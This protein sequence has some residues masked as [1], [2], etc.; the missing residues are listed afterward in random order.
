MRLRRF[1]GRAD[2][3]GYLKNGTLV[4]VAVAGIIAGLLL[5]QRLMH[6]AGA[7]PVDLDWGTVV[8][9]VLATGA[10]FV[11]SPVAVPRNPVGSRA[12]CIDAVRAT[13]TGIAI[14]S[15]AVALS[16]A[17]SWAGWAVFWLAASSL[18]SL[19]VIAPR[20]SYGYALRIARFARRISQ[21]LPTVR[22][23][24][25]FAGAKWRIRSGWWSVRFWLR[26][27]DALDDLAEQ[28][29][30]HPSLDPGVTSGRATAYIISLTPVTD[31]PRVLRQT[32]MLLDAGWNVVVAGFAGRSPKPTH[33]NLLCVQHGTI[34]TDDLAN[35][36]RKLFLRGSKFSAYCAERYYWLSA[37]YPH[38]F[39]SL[40]HTYD[41]HP[42]LGCNLVIAHDYYTAPIAARLAAHCGVEFAIDCH[43]YATG[44]Y[45]HDETWRLT[46][47][48]WVHAIQKRFLPRAAVVTTVCDG[49][50]SLID[51]EYKLRTPAKVVRSMP[52]FVEMPFRP[53]GEVIEVLYHGIL[54]PIRGLD[55]AM[56]SVPYWRPEFRLVIR[57]PG[58]DEYIASLRELAAACGVA[59]RVKIDPPVLFSE[60]IAAANR[61]DIGFF[62]H[63]DVSPQ[64]RFVLPNKLFEYIMAGMAICVSDLPE[65]AKVVRAHDLG[66]LVQGASPLDIARAINSFSR[67]DIDRFKANSIAAAKKLCWD[68]ES[69]AMHAAYESLLGGSLAAASG[70]MYAQQQ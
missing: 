59:D 23:D 26:L 48:P 68:S 64:K 31:E 40:V 70:P 27:L 3:I 9:S 45:M 39:K 17:S 7:G 63:E 58:T 8:L 67:A 25:K 24:G 21:A 62:V 65:M 30:A 42:E 52:F 47:R 49:I 18:S 19:C 12:D 13:V 50:A 10:V 60:M 11:F 34:R 44:Q 6:A 56:R 20:A 1:A 51:R 43:E 22:P 15:M 46:Y 2:M 14:A 55:A 57:G 36:L 66:L 37:G 28:Q 54:D 41:E 38:I 5:V 16:G 29:P 35:R 32:R 33:W 61:S 69:R 53:S 4:G